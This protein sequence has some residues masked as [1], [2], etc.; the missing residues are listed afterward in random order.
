L[1]VPLVNAVLAA[2]PVEEAG[3]AS[4]LFSTGQQL[5]GALG[6]ALLGTVFFGYL[7]G[8]HSFEAALV[9]TAPYA[10][11]V[12][13]LRHPVDAAPAHRG[14]RG[15][16]HRVLTPGEGPRIGRSWGL[17]VHGLVSSTESNSQ[18]ARRA[19]IWPAPLLR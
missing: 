1:V 11:G 15:G 10:M 5:G 13:P 4:G 17:P 2:V 9:H 6:V 18:N 3:G 14:V 12:R 16:P 7:G 19:A 8:G